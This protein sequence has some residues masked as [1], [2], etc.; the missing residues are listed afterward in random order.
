MVN[1][2][3]FR[4]MVNYLVVWAFSR[5]CRCRTPIR[6]NNSSNIIITI[7]IIFLPLSVRIHTI[8][9]NGYFPHE[10]AWGPNI[11][12]HYHVRQPS[13]FS[14]ISYHFHHSFSCI[15]RGCASN[16]YILSYIIHIMHRVI[17]YI[18]HIINISCNIIYYITKCVTA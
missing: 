14:F 17:S 10:H 18:S 11:F 12:I 6:N 16:R 8:I 2:N 7:M 4:I 5:S 15:N 1:L 9:K 3:F 13:P